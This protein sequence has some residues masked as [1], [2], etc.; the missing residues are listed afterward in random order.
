MSWFRDLFF[1]G[2]GVAHAVLIL[3][4][5]A[6]LGLALG[7][8]KVF[9][10]SLGVAG[11][12]FAG[13]A[14]GHFHFHIN[15]EVLEFARDFGLILFV[16]TIGVQVGPGFMSS[17]KKQGLPLNIM[18]ASIVLLG[19][20][21]TLAAYHLGMAKS[22]FPAV[23]GIFSGATTNT[24]SLAAATAALT[25]VV[26]AKSPVLAMPGLGYAIAYP[27]GVI[28]IIVTMLLIKFA[29]KMDLTRE[30]ELVEKLYGKKEELLTAVNVQVSNPRV[31]GV[32]LKKLP[33][34]AESG[35]VVSR[36]LRGDHPEIA[37][38]DTVLREGDVLLAVGPKP[39]IEQFKM[40][41]GDETSVDLKAM[42]STITTKRV[43]VT[44]SQA[45]GKTVA[46]LQ[47][48]HRFGVTITR[49]RRG[50]V[51]LPVTSAVHLQFGDSVLVVGEEAAIEQ[52]S[53]ELGNSVKRLNQ[54]Q[55]IPVFVGIIL[56]VIVGSWPIALPG[57]PA[58]VKLGLAGG[59]L[60]MALILSRIGK[61]GPLVWHMPSSANHMLRE[62]GIVM[63]LSCVGLK[64]GDKF[65]HILTQGHGV[66]WMAYGAIITAVPLLA[67]ALVARIFYKVDYYSI[68]GLLA[69]SMTDPPALAFAGSLTN[70][71]TPSIA[72]A[73]V[74]PLV[75]LLRVV[76]A[77]AMVMF[78]F[79]S[80]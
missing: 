8:I 3:G 1:Q 13:L 4:L 67:V 31:D 27:F 80:G 40:V 58:P 65:V 48:T 14:F 76:S 73:T 25:D 68:C 49:I 63:F 45:L 78:F 72:Y 22:E 47:L 15:D 28:G 19:V 20:V 6:A 32:K 43:F 70:S 18:A 17:F 7:T 66:T 29:F 56:G 35:V 46:D 51:E 23:V 69:G 62:L 2:E 9:K 79:R 53:I 39:A 10:I 57:F 38:P 52:V 12:L 5:V 71:E 42:P 37:L 41:V 61:I 54:G 21:L 60:V 16:Y 77:Q 26:G 50:D 11:V 36:V 75:M 34:L 55:I 74:Y 44:K 24:P 30:S 59:P 33:A 64:S